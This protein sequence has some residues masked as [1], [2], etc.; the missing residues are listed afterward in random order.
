MEYWNN[1][2]MAKVKRI[3]QTEVRRQN[4]IRGQ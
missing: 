3:Q 1:G 2:I 4:E